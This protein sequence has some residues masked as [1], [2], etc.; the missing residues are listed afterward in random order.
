VTVTAPAGFAAN[1]LVFLHQ[2]LGTGVGAWEVVSVVSVSGSTLTLAS[3]LTNTYSSA[4][5]N[6]A[7]AVVMPQ[8]TSVTQTGGTVT[9]PAWD[10]ATGGIL[11]F[12]SVGAVNLT[13]GSID[14]SARGYRGHAR[15]SIANRAGEQGE[16]STTFGVQ[17][18][19]A[20]TNG[21]GGGGRT[22]C[23]C[24]WAGAGGGG[25]HAASGGAGSPGGNTCQPG[26]AGGAAIG[27][28]QQTVMYF[29]GAGANGG[30]DE[31]GHGSAGA[32]GGG[33]IYIAAS[34]INVTSGTVTNDGQAGQGE[35][36]FA[37]CGSGGGGGGAGGAIYLRAPTVALGASRV[38][39][40][41]G[42]GGDDGGNC[43]TPGGA[44]SVGRVT[45]RGAT[46]VTGASVPMHATAP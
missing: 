24:C 18:T 22:G 34:A 26:G 10:G 12:A 29:G 11:A 21:G 46:T 16:G 2:S 1:Q 15:V 28:A 6:R 33:L 19:A 7:Q 4:G 32:T 45:L 44:G 43:G 8:Y 5:A 13:G 14:M 17:S 31:D 37:G 30:A 25:G 3:P 41:G 39:S 27:N 42:A 36:N 35:F 9:A 20:N 38:L 40:R 23:D